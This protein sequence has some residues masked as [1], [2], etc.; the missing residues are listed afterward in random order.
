MGDEGKISHE[1][2]A[3]FTRDFWIGFYRSDSFVL[4]DE[5]VVCGFDGGN[6]WL[7]LSS[8]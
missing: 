4:D 1:I 2:F 8:V 3:G 5:E 7:F 6:Y